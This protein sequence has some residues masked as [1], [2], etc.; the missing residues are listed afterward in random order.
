MEWANPN[1]F[2]AIFRC[3][4]VK[5]A[6]KLRNE[7]SVMFNTPRRWSEIEKEKRKG[8]GDIYEGVFA[9]CNLY[10]IE[11]IIYNINRY[12]DVESFSDGDLVY[13]RRSSVVDMPAYCFFLLK[14]ELFQCTGTAGKQVIKANIPGKY[15]QDFAHGI[16]KERLESLDEK[17]RPSLVIIKDMDKFIDMIKY[18]LIKL[19]VNKSQI[20][21]QVITYDNKKTPFHCTAN[22]P[23][24]LF[25][26]DDSFRYQ[27]EGRIVINIRDKE[28]LDYL[29]RNPI[30]IGS[31]KEFSTISD[32]YFEKG[33]LIEMTAMICEVK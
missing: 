26:K 10:D 31:I 2:Y 9:A 23:Y 24:E 16:S 5:Y 32:T 4:D 22:S 7:G 20:I 17:D 29:V 3:T 1:E 13:F 12:D 14:Q 21:T 27:S 28:L 18:K 15:F 19:G 6:N 33:M 8:Q 25:I 30:N 11:S